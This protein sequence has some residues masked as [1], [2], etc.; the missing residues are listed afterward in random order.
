MLVHEDARAVVAGDDARRGV[1]ARELVEGSER[2]FVLAVEAVQS[3]LD[4]IDRRLVRCLLREPRHFGA[5][6]L[7]LAARK[8]DEDHQDARLDD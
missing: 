3:A 2:A 6:L 8:I 7:L 4:E 5:R 1:E